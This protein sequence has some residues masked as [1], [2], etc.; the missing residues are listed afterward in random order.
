MVRGSVQPRLD[1]ESGGGLLVP[2]GR[3]KPPSVGV[4]FDTID[5]DAASFL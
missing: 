2:S 5:L 4:C 3:F 1:Q